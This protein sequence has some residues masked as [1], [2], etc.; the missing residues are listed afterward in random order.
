MQPTKQGTGRILVFASLAEIEPRPVE[1]VWRNRIPLGK[2][3]IFTGDPDVGKTQVLIDIMARI[4]TGERWPDG[5]GD[6]PPG[7]VIFLTGEDSHDDTIRPRAEAAGADLSRIHVLEAA[8]DEDGKRASFH[9]QSDLA[10]L[11][12]QIREIGDVKLI[13]IDPI[14]CYL[15]AGKIDTHKTSD[16]RAL[17]AELKEFAEEHGVTVCSITH[18]PKSIGSKAMNAATGSLAFMAA[19]RAGYL[20]MRD[21]EN[22]RSLMLPIKSNLGRSVGGL[23]YRFEQRQVTNDIV[24]SHVIWDRDPVTMT[25]DE[26][27][28]AANR[29]TSD[30]SAK[31]DA[32]DFLSDLL[33]N[34]PMAVGEIENEARAAGLLSAS[35]PIGQSKPFRSAR[36]NL[37]VQSKKDGMKGGWVWSLPKVPWPAEDA[38]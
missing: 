4:T 10:L 11:S 35:Q 22:D 29:G 33:A 6:A 1:W 19:A 12:Q 17:L 37:G 28:A 32:A 21:P 9:L 38:F 36:D 34:G 16:V 8:Y 13:G 3:V 2:Q 18:P 26:V 25:A 30:P 27:L 31:G 24:A 23:S 14:T 15:G 20:F 7:S 5:S